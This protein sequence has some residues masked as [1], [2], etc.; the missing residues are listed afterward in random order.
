M[1]VARSGGRAGLRLARRAV[2]DRAREETFGLIHPARRTTAR[3]C[4]S[5]R[6]IPADPDHRRPR[7]ELDGVEGRADL[8]F[9]IRRGVNS[10]TARRSRR[11][12]SRLLRQDHHAAARAD[13]PAP[14][15]S[16]AGGGVRGARRRDRDLPAQAPRRAGFLSQPGPGRG[17]G[18]TRPT[19]WP[20]TRT[21]TRRN[22]PGLGPSPVEHV[23]GSHWVGGSSPTTATAPALLDGYR[24]S[25]SPTPPRAWRACAPK[26]ARS[27]PAR[28]NPSARTCLWPRSPRGSSSRRA[29]GLRA[30]GRAAPRERS[31]GRPA[32]APCA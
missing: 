4:V 23:K 6:P 18:S 21:G 9:K 28:S 14:G 19:S 1:P 12:T 15:P 27:S 16:T 13:E 30:L 11:A 10:T 3:C 22:H 17:T 32:R 20:R 29:R 31:P 25:S 5:I 8:A 26:R 24:R 7:R 2:H